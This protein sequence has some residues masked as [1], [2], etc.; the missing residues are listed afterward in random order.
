MLRRRDF[1]H[2]WMVTWSVKRSRL[3]P[4]L[5]QASKNPWSWS[6]PPTRK[7]NDPWIS[8]YS[9]G[10]SRILTTYNPILCW[11][12]LWTLGQSAKHPKEHPRNWANQL[13]KQGPMQHWNRWKPPR[14]A[15]T[16][17]EV[18]AFQGDLGPHTIHGTI[19]YFLPTWIWLIFMGNVT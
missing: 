2:R 12:H 17:R 9:T 13:P 16:F 6:N 3:E 19:V 1:L 7:L 8:A 4:G 11:R 15:T 10:V 18:P 14:P 5:G